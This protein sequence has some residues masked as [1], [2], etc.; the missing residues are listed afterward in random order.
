[1]T[2]RVTAKSINGSFLDLKVQSGKVSFKASTRLP[3]RRFWLAIAISIALAACGAP[4]GVEPSV[5]AQV[6]AGDWRRY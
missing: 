3:R 2:I 6:A 5:A 4:T 1:M